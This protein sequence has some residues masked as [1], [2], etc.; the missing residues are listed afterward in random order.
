MLLAGRL[1]TFDSPIHLLTCIYHG[2]RRRQK[3]D[4]AVSRLIGPTEGERRQAVLIRLLVM[5][6]FLLFHV[7]VVQAQVVS[8]DYDSLLIGVDPAGGT[9]T[10]YYANF[11]GLDEST[12]KPLF[13]CIFFLKGSMK[14]PPPYTIDTWFPADKTRKDLITGSLTPVESDGAAALKIKL[15]KEHGG[16]WN[17]EHF[18]DDDGASFQTRGPR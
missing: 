17:V 4:K 3:A 9:I 7:V 5:V 14:G 16:C 15:P 8:G 10:G 12:G 13:N 2:N 11:T 1:R 18:A 6:I